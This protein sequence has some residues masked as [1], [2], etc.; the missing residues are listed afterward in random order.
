VLIRLLERLS[1][2]EDFVEE[3]AAIRDEIVGTPDG[4]SWDRVLERIADLI[5]AIRGQAQREKQD[6]E[7]FLK[8]LGERLQE[9]DRQ[10]QSSGAFY[11][12]A[13]EAGE[14]LDSAVKK[15]MTGIGNSVRDASDLDQLKQVVRKHIDTVTAHLDR[16][17]L[18]ERRRHEE[19]KHQIVAMSQRLNAMEAEA[20][21]LR[22]RVQ[23][24]RN[25]AMTDALTG[26]PNRLAYEERLAQEV[27]RWKRFGT[28]LV[29]VV[30]D[31]DHFKKVNDRFGHKAGDKVLRAVARVLADHV[32][33]T[34]FVARYGGEEFAMLMTGSSLAACLHVAEKL[35][36][37]VEATGF[38]FRDEAVIITASCG[39]AD[40]RDGDSTEQWFERADR[41]LY[42]AKQEGRNRCE[43]AG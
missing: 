40:I 9:V 23:E 30:W 31:I 32:R 38:H 25:Q 11:D 10:L 39:L 15:E 4:G 17:R 37:A 2:P 24:E 3:V 29:L 20:D 36:A 6:V 28:P 27:A 43:I 12:A 5:E 7:T 26:I 21:M 8:Q 18:S 13:Q 14:A 42:R 19:A 33:E 41:A 16:H 22:S 34:D 35:R 1:M